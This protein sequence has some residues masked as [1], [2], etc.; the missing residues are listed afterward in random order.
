MRLDTKK[1]KVN[2]NKITENVAKTRLNKCKTTASKQNET[3]T[4]NRLFNKNIKWRQMKKLNEC[5]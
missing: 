5:K 4:L 3:K 2:M 1:K